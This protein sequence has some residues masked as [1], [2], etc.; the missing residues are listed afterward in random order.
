MTPCSVQAIDVVGEPNPKIIRNQAQRIL[1]MHIRDIRHNPS[2]LKM[3]IEA[4]E[5]A[6]GD[7][8]VLVCIML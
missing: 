3:G 7:D 8:D 2:F 5:M 1:R 4:V 6:L